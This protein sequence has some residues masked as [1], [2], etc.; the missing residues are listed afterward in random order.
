LFAQAALSRTDFNPLE[1]N[2]FRSTE[3]QVAKISD[4]TLATEFG[5]RFSSPPTRAIDPNVGGFIPPERFA[6]EH[7]LNSRSDLWGL[8]AVIY[9]ALTGC[10][11][12]D[13]RGREPREVI[14]RDEPVPLRERESAVPA[15]LAE[16]IDRALRPNPAHRYPSAAEMKAAWD[17]AFKS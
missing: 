4:F 14:S 5:R 13:F 3:P 1:R 15:S 9:H 16:V 11:P 8:A 6:S 2:E 17:A 12:W 10:Y 7:G